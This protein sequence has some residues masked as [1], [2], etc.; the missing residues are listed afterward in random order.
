MLAVLALKFRSLLGGLA[1]RGL[2]PPGGCAVTTTFFL[3]GRQ[4]RGGL[5]DGEEQAR[6]HDDW[7]LVTS[8]SPS[9]PTSCRSGVLEIPVNGLRALQRM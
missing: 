6:S 1:V 5:T 4:G 7:W 8:F 2:G 9:F 3:L